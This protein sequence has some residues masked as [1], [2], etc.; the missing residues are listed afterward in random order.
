ME[1]PLRYSWIIPRRLAVGE[2][3]RSFEE[4][5]TSGFQAVLSLQ[6]EEEG[7]PAGEP[8]PADRYRRVPIR[9]GI[10]GG[11]PTPLQIAEA[12]EALRRFQDQG[13]V[14]YVHCYAG[15]GRSPTVCMAYL[16]SRD[17]LRLREAYRL[18][19]AAHA[20]TAPTA[21]QL[22]ALAQF[23]NAFP[24]GAGGPPAGAAP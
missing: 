20:P 10:V 12:V 15:V 8:F 1:R 23:L 24:G 5:S 14:T 18:V 6:E 16:A 2:R 21:G 22:A 9:D 13:L 19:A 11:V 7:V 17:S 3:P 4:L